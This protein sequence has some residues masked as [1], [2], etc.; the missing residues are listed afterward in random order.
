MA[1]DESSRLMGICFLASLLWLS[2]TLDRHSLADQPRLSAFLVLLVS[3]ALAFILSCFPKR[4]PGADGRFDSEAVFKGLKTSL[5][6]RPRRFYVPCIVV[7]VVVRLEILYRVVYDFQCTVQGVEAFLPLLLATHEFLFNRRSQ[8]VISDEPE[9][10]WGD[11]WEEFLD[12]LKGSQFVLLLSTLLFCYGAFLVADFTP[13]SSYFCSTVSDRTFWVIFLQWTG[14]FLDA[15]ILILLWR[16]LSWART[17]KS[18]LRTLSGILTV[19][20][21]AA[22]FL[23]SSSRLFQRRSIISTQSFRGLDSLFV[24]DVMSTGITCAT[25][26]ISTTLWM[27]ESAPLTLTATATFF[28]GLLT[29]LCQV[30]LTGSYRQASS[31]QPLFVLSI[32][33]TSFSI[34]TYANNMRSI[35]YIRRAF[36]LLLLVCVI[37]A[38]TIFSLLRNKPISRHPV[39]E[40]VYES[41]VETDRWLRHATVSTT[42]K[43]AV[44]EYKERHHGRDPPANFDKWYDFAQQRNSVII[45][46]YDQIEKDLLPYWGMKPSKIRDGLEIV[47]ELPDVGIIKVVEGKAY[48]N[49]PADPSHR[50]VLDDT[51]SMISSFA[52]YL[53]E[54]SIVINLKER[55]RILVPWDDIYRLTNAGKKSKSN[56]LPQALTRRQAEDSKTPEN[57]VRSTFSD[58]PKL[59]TGPYVSTKAFHHLQALA[60]PPGSKTRA[61]VSWNVRD[62]CASCADPHSYGQ[63]LMNWGYSLD[64][65]HQPDIFHLHDFHT[66]PQR[67]ELYQDLLP[68]FSKSKTDSFNDILMPIMWP[69]SSHEPDNKRVDAK[70]DTL[71][72][73]QDPVQL[74][75][76]THQSLHGGHRHR[77]VRLLNNATAFDKQ[78]MLLG[79]QSNKEPKFSYED[80]GIREVNKNLPIEVSYI[81][82]EKCEDPSCQAIVQEQFGF[83]PRATAL[84]NRYIVL[85]DTA[86]G[87]SPDVLPILRSNS[88]PMISTIFREWFSERLMPWTHFVPIDIRYHGLHSTLAYFVGLKGRGKIN[89]HDQLMEPRTADAKW[90]AEQGRKW[91]DKAIRREDMEVYM[92]RLLLEW[93]RVIN[94]ERDSIGFALKDGT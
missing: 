16:V 35:M 42:L 1:G 82:P 92:F 6:Q 22:G 23:W 9:D 15:V 10:P 64:P 7:L 71:F 25:L 67:F 51:V 8:P 18:R 58:A 73:Q 33:C 77:F 31:F 86:D 89:G 28:S 61:G 3:G 72:W 94:D 5:P 70:S 46:K 19:S 41:R 62:H 52:E 53:P 76:V 34:F 68:L 2:Y 93:G 50:L 88:V 20:S 11:F 78:S 74:Q 44:S 26:T 80:I 45:D 21:L 87:P 56:L 90:I 12:W 17:T 79:I 27:C 69:N 55:P 49:Q 4:L 84:A 91:A 75:T 66:I 57:P 43:L 65:C 29:T 13:R 59:T 81:Y 32:I 37:T 30:L 54:M 39:D 36:L 83:R 40:F 47:K 63:F 85:L 14:V 48:H 38:A 60:C 24:F